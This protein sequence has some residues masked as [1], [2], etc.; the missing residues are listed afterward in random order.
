MSISVEI[1]EGEVVFRHPP[2]YEFC[3]RQFDQL[4]DRLD[5]E[6][7]SDKEYLRR[8]GDLT[9]RYPLFIDG[10][11]HIGFEQLN[12]GRVKAALKSLERGFNL[13]EAALPPDFSGTLKWTHLDNR[14]FL[15]A[16]SGVVECRTAL[17]E[18]AKAVALMEK[19]LAWDPN[20][21]QGW[22]WQIGSEYFRSGRMEDA[23]EV[24]EANA[25]E[26]P[27]YWY[28]FGLYWLQ[29]KNH[30][31][32]ATCLRL[33]FV[34]NPYVA[35]ALFGTE[36]ILPLPIWHGTNLAGPSTAQ[37]YASAYG[38]LWVENLES[39]EF[40]RWLHGHPKMLA[41]RAAIFE[42]REALLWEADVSKRGRILDREDSLLAE[43]DDSLSEKLVSARVDRDGNEVMPWTITTAGLLDT[44]A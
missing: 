34:S 24:F 30:A 7:I 15:R 38:A 27:P 16:A 13:G 40:L 37:A 18:Q 4:L 20:D 35:E 31:K 1:S 8:L 39:M 28:E 9:R 42:C 6:E 2:E 32:A 12:R 11:V 26:Y 10:H 36:F 25:P 22:R 29:R 21:H 43:I 14:P 19:I 33:G 23:R 3:F 41:E 5:S 44:F 17:G